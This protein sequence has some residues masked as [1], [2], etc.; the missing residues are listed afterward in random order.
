MPQRPF[1][2]AASARGMHPFPMTVVTVKM[3]V[4]IKKTAKMTVVT[5]MT[6]ESI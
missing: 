4:T 1:L 3:T 6:V 5:V 2:P